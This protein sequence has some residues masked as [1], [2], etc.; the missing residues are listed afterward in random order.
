MWLPLSAARQSAPAGVRVGLV[1][2]YLAQGE[3]AR[4]R[5]EF[6]RLRA[7]APDLA[8]GLASAFPGD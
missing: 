2:A 8:R 3:T 4:A 7:T 1:R 6:L 5:E